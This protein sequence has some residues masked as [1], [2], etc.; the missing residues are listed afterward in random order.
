MG[1]NEKITEQAYSEAA[2]NPNI[3]KP[4]KKKFV[5]TKQ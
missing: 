3:E 4:E 5:N 1:S 2:H